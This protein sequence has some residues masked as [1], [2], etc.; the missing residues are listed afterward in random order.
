[1]KKVALQ[2]LSRAKK[3]QLYNNFN[4]RSVDDKVRSNFQSAHVLLN[5][6]VHVYSSRFQ[7][8]L[9]KLT[10]EYNTYS[11]DRAESAQ[12]QSVNQWQGYL[13]GQ[14]IIT[15]HHPLTHPCTGTFLTIELFFSL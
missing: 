14:S 1:M 7:T 6:K 13:H 4:Q 11:R 10:A 15:A 2:E 5:C 12:F 9:K 3:L 8:V